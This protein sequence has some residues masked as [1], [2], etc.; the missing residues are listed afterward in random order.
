MTTGCLGS[1]W[2]ETEG[3]ATKDDGTSTKVFCYDKGVAKT[4]MIMQ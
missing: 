1:S 4:S 3:H 2:K